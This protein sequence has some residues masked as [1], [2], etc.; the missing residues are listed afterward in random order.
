MNRE[1]LKQLED[2]LWSAADNLRANSDLK[3]SEYSTPVLGLIFL[4]FADINYRRHEVAILKEYQKLKGTRREKSLNEIAVAKCGFY[5]PD[6]ARYSH[7]LN[8]PENQDIAKAI[9]K[10]M[11]AIEEYKPEL[12]GS[13]PKDE[14]YR[15]TRTQETKLLP[16]DLLRQFDNIPD[17]AT[18]DVFGQIY[19]YFL[20]KF[21]LSEGQGGGEFF[22]PRSVV[23]LMVEIIEP[24][25]GTVF[26][27]A[28]G[29]G[30][31]FVQS[32]QFIEKHKEEYEAQGEDTSVFV[33][34]QEKSSETVKLARM[35]LAVN[36]L[37]G[38]ILQGISY[39]DDHFDSFGN[40]DYVL[41]NPPF[42]VD[43]VSLSGVEKDPRFNT[44]G[45]P[46]KKT[47]AKKSEQGKET[48]PNANYLWINLFA[49]SLREPDNKH[50]GG[51]AALVMA[52]SASDAR[53]SEADIR[54]T[55]IENNLIYSMLTLPSN[56]FYT[57]TLPATLWFFD[58][59]KTDERILF[60][61]ARNIFT[62]I[63][64]AHREFSEEQ[65]QN[66][67]IISRLH[68]GR[69]D[70][71]VALI[72]RYFEQGMA[73][74]AENQKQVEPVTEQILSV[75][76]DKEGK[77]AVTSLLDTW[78]GLAPLQKAWAS[79]QKKNTDKAA[80]DKKNRAQHKLR[81][82]FDPFFTALHDSLKQIDKA[83][84]RHEKALAEAAKQA[85][86]RQS[87]DR[88][89]RQLK[90]ALEE[91]HKEVKNAE[92]SFGHIHWLQERFPEAEYEDVTGLCKLADLDDVKE[93]D[94][95]LNP[96]RY[97][98]VVIEE[99]GKTEEEFVETI[100]SLQDELDELAK[101]GK[102][103][104]SIISENIGK[105]TQ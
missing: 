2:D 98:G 60:I 24:H 29:S 44:Y 57:V 17:D 14:Y 70:E 15:L 103:L 84:R 28:C 94:Y 6:H 104:Q 52:N 33:S 51:R 41:A 78:K 13:L 43:E 25:G 63:D 80:A 76:D 7:L 97:V 100:L 54:R 81:A 59:G 91:L 3:A 23:R 9:E 38:Q 21:A 102:S 30:G 86:K 67:A 34:G 5:L 10:A 68:K 47:K 82:T 31:M 61:D 87:A 53:H 20:G 45:I 11:E 35:N 4:K 64:R 83:V 89:T 74:L 99:D 101:S 77:Q 69:R 32:A 75:L 42:N 66:I 22:T 90:A 56:M 37:R 55:L 72:D 73:R 46:R 58:K 93:Q 36:G 39:Y 88:A 19:E 62:P 49:T 96:G 27:P 8:L 79:Y 26:D 85:G 65:I 50:P 105:I 71:F 48:V 95:S 40:F 92:S 18:G 12:Q 1:Q 16:F